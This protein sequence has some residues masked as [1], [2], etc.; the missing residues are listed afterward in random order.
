M[1]LV[2]KFAELSVVTDESLEACVNLWVGQG[3]TLDRIHFVVTDH[4]RRPGMAFV[5]FLREV[6]DDDGDQRTSTT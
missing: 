2:Y 4:S 1:A 5:S 3:W 6:D